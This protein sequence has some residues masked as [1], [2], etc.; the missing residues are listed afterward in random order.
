MDMSNKLDLAELITKYGTD[1][2]QDFEG[3]SS[4]EEQ[5]LIV[6]EI[7]KCSKLFDYKEG[8]KEYIQTLC[9]I[10]MIKI[11]GELQEGEFDVTYYVSKVLEYM[12]SWDDMLTCR[13]L[14][15]SGIDWNKGE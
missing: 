7:K 5:E 11:V 12:A 10:V 9:D 1:C 2:F 4:S 3:F 8:D 14:S 15:K 6:N 13:Y